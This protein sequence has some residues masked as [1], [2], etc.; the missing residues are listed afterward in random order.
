MLN[1]MLFK[2]EKENFDPTF[3]ENWPMSQEEKITLKI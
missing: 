2:L 3:V 1:N